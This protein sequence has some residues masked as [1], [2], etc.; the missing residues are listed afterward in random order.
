MKYIL[1]LTILMS[2]SIHAKTENLVSVMSYNVENLFDFT[3]DEGKD[4]YTYLPL[5]VK[6]ASRKIQAHCKSLG[7]KHYVKT[8][9]T[10][11]WSEEVVKQ[12][13]KNIA[14]VI[15][16]YNLGR[17]AD[18]LVLQEVENLNVLKLMIKYELHKYGYHY[19]ALEEGPDSRGIDT[20]VISKYPIVKTK[21]HKIDLTGIAK[22]S[23]GIMETQVLVGNKI[24]TLFGNH[25]PSQANPTEARR[26]AALTLVRAAR[27]ASGDIVM[28]LGDF[29]TV[30]AR[31]IPNPIEEVLMPNFFDAE[32]RA[33]RMGR[34]LAE[35]THWFAGKWDSLDKIFVLKNSMGKNVKVVYP[36]FKIVKEDFMLGKKRWVDR[37]TGNV[38]I[39]EG[40][41]YRFYSVEGKG[42]SDHLPIVVKVK[43]K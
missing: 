37:A 12:K 13:I 7:K 28:A 40:V 29:N 34:S 21:L 8:C 6:K 27:A 2:F 1:V 23:R 9:L 14:Q 26:Q 19:A 15:R 25:W 33:R 5:K 35:G 32:K 18:I 16:A 38:T 11:D 3:H 43:L 39:Y 41:P 4:D 22:E 36:S 10:L 42:Y 20:G 31:D 24:I 30:A 17:G